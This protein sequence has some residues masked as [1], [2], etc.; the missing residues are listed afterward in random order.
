MSN[1][2]FTFK[3]TGVSIDKSVISKAARKNNDTSPNPIGISFPLMKG[4]RQ[5]ESLFMMNFDLLEQ[6]KNNIKL[7]IMTRK[8]EKLGSIDFGTDIADVINDINLDKSEIEK[9]VYNE[10]SISI[11]KFFPFVTLESFSL[12]KSRS[13]GQDIEMF[14]L[15]VDFKINNVSNKTNQ[16]IINFKSSK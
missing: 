1:S 10:L 7:L 12:D 9:K 13:S 14:K 3:N 2:E 16:L 4:Y 11:K 15:I 8:G 6:V 5:K